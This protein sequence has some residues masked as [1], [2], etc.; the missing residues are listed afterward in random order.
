MNPN[1]HTLTNSQSQTPW[2]VIGAGLCGLATCLELE[3]RG[4]TC[5]LVEATAQIGGKL[6]TEIF[7]DRYLLD[8]GFQVLLPA[9][10][11]LRKNVD[12]KALN[13][14][15]FNA[16]AMIRIDQDW[17]QISDPLRNPLSIFKT[18]FS[19]IGNFYDKLLVI[20]LR[21]SVLSQKDDLFF[22]KPIGTSRDYL[23]KFGFS[24]DMIENFWTPFFSGI[25]LESEL[26]TEASLLRFLFKMFSQSPVALPEKGI[27]ELPNLMFSNLKRTEL[28]L[29]SVVTDIQQNKIFLR[30]NTVLEGHIIDTRPLVTANWGSVTTLYFAADTSPISGPW[31][32]LNS[33]KN[34]CM[35]NHV[36]VLSEVSK[37]YASRGDA[38]ISVNLIVP[39]YS[40]Q[41]FARVIAELTEMFGIQVK[42]WRFLKSFE[43]S[44]AL[45][46]YL[47]IPE[48]SKRLNTPSQQGAFVRA[49]QLISE[50]SF[51]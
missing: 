1:H 30:D 9:Y 40:S 11:E 2:I 17:T 41:D 12:L 37:H 44:Q 46:L 16:G 29:N 45:P 32:I 23:Q 50:A 27:C 21:L 42:T 13:L 14:K 22:E 38:L 19:K 36:A 18:L 47:S 51:G 10:S 20:K 5:V 24:L 6:K 48:N 7:E 4:R 26:K 28:R 3:K 49:R 25:F 31:L 15:Y 43:I 39:N 8:H 34:K 33:K 35:V